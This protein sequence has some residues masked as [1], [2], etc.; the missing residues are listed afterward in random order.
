ME[1]CNNFYKCDSSWLLPSSILSARLRN[2]VERCLRSSARFWKKSFSATENLVDANG[3]N[4]FFSYSGI[5]RTQNKSRIVMGFFLNSW[6]FNSR[7]D[8]RSEQLDFFQFFFS[9]SRLVSNSK[10]FA[11]SIGHRNDKSFI[12]APHLTRHVLEPSIL[13]TNYYLDVKQTNR[14]YTNSSNLFGQHCV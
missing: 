14:G 13:F 11:P 8:F 2:I 12:F 10:L 3:L 4:F 7:Y 6:K 5:Q 9:T 1:I